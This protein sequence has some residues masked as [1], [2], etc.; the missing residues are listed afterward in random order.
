[1]L[2]CSGGSAPKSWI[3][4]AASGFQ[5]STSLQRPIT[6]AGKP[7]IASSSRSVA[8]GTFGGAV[9]RRTRRGGGPATVMR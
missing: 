8:G 5:A 3:S 7:C 1:M 6:M 9:V 2:R 4:A